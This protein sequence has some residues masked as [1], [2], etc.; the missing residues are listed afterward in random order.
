MSF[1]DLGDIKKL[2]PE[3]MELY[4]T[5]GSNW[6]ALSKHIKKFSESELLILIA[7]EHQTVKREHII[8]RLHSRYCRLRRDRE[9]NELLGVNSET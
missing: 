6:S 3:Y 2:A 4:K 8:K 7:I 1:Q 5:T 9:L